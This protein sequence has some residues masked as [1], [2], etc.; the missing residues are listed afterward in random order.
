MEFVLVELSFVKTISSWTI[1]LSS[2]IH[3]NPIRVLVLVDLDSR[4]TG[5]YISDK[6]LHSFNL[7]LQKEEV[8][9]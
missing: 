4:S 9:E 8:Y 1:E 5:N 2:R 7:I 6:I 3:K